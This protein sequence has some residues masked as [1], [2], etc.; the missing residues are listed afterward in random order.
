MLD[1]NITVVHK[2]HMATLSEYLKTQQIT[3]AQF[4]AR[5]GVTQ[6]YIAKLCARAATPAL[7][8]AYAIERETQGKVLASQWIAPQDQGRAA[9]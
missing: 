4:A 3:Q 8:T 7:C 9:S 1:G 2:P 5:I 6:G